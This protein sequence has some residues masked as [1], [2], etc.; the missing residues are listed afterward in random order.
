MIGEIKY[1]EKKTEILLASVLERFDHELNT[2][3]KIVGEIRKDVDTLM[4]DMG[5]VKDDIKSV[6]NDV[7]HLTLESLRK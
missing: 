5:K 3:E 6:R 2:M 4:V 7:V 1:M